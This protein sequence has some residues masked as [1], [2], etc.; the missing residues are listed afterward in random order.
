VR[1]VAAE[2]LPQVATSASVQKLQPLM[3][4]RHTGVAAAVKATLQRIA[5][6]EFDEISLALKELKGDDVFKRR[7][8]LKALAGMT[9]VEAR[10]DEVNTVLESLVLD[11]QNRFNIGEN[12]ADALA[13]WAT[14]KTANKIIPLLNNPKLDSW[15]RPRLIKSVSGLHDN[16]TAAAAVMKW[17]IL[18]PDE[19]V[20]SLTQMG[21]VAEDEM[22]RIFNANFGNKNRD[23][24]VVRNA[25]LR[26]LSEIGTNKSLDVL[27]RASRDQRDPVSQALALSAID[28]VKARTPAATQPAKA[29]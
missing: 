23:G 29:Q 9:P 7:D 2:L 3:C 27:T 17:V 20:K 6:G 24:Q 10:R 15:M 22:I 13:T 16:K 1:S 25:C 11:P 19:V 14:A 18:A 12:A 21:P 26:I 8:V 5:P 4:R 28:A